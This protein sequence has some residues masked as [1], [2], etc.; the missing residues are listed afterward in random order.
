MA[1]ARPCQPGRAFL[2]GRDRAGSGGQKAPGFARRQVKQNNQSGK[3]QNMKKLLCILSICILILSMALPAMAD[4][5]YLIPDSNT[6]R[7]TEAE[8]WN[9]DRESLSFIFNEI[10]ARHGYVFNRGGKYDLWFSA[11]PWYQPNAS[12]DNQKYVYPY[13][14][15]LEWDNYHLIKDVIAKM[16]ALGYKAHD[17]SLKCY[18]NFTPPQ[19]GWS[20][21][22]FTYLPL[23]AEQRLNVYSAPGASSWRGANGRAMVNTSGAVWAAGWDQGWLLVYYET[24]NNSIR[25]GYV[26]GSTIQG[27]V[28]NRTYLSF[29]HAAAT[30]TRSCS[31]TDDPMKA[32]ITMA[33]LNAG[34]QVTYLSTFVNQYGEVWDYIQTWV[35]GQQA[36]GFIPQG[37]LDYALDS[38]I[39]GWK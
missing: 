4:S 9:W 6:R 36:R 39:E 3:E 32:R 35:N 29:D 21:T 2:S 12:S 37:C 19:G 30:V 14:S 20:L 28:N 11:M 5:L 15:Q 16:D 17:N 10:F 34:A 23:K 22:G 33:T 7:L 26:D 13:V 38:G 31:M 18:R 1:N 8:L 27:T 25:V 24:N